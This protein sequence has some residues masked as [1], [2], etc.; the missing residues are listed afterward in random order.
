MFNDTRG[1]TGWVYF[2]HQLRDV[3]SSVTRLGVNSFV[4]TPS[5]VF[6]FGA[7]GGVGVLAGVKT[8]VVNSGIPE[9]AVGN[10]WVSHVGTSVAQCE[11]LTDSVVL[12]NVTVDTVPNCNPF[13]A[14]EDVV[15]VVWGKETVLVESVTPEVLHRLMAG[16][17]VV[18]EPGCVNL[19]PRRGVRR[20]L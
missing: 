2:E 20:G 17:V 18:G 1:V 13:Q 15:N 12:V 16:R 3:I 10:R 9:D 19:N 11:R 5:G 14:C 7:T 4:V 8:S 6:V